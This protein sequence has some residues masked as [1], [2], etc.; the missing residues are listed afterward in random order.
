MFPR[1]DDIVAGVPAF[2]RYLP[3]DE[4][5]ASTDRFAAAHPE[6]EV[7]AVGAWRRG[8]EIR[9][10]ELGTGPLQTLVQ[11]QLAAL[12]CTLDAVRERYRPTHPRPAGPRT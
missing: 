5:E 3:V 11:A 6:V 7:V 10:L 4:L 8:H 12:L 1:Y 2:E 9:C